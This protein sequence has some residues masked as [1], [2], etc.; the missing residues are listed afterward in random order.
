MSTGRRRHRRFDINDKVIGAFTC[1]G[2]KASFELQNISES[3]V[4]VIT[5]KRL[6]DFEGVI[7]FPFRG[8]I[9]KLRSVWKKPVSHDPV[10]Y[11]YGLTRIDETSDVID[12][13]L[14]AG[15]VDED[16]ID[17]YDDQPYVD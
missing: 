11:K 9:L 7:E 1:D 16:L 6:P 17:G 8:Q 5:Q 2:D 4:C 13:F 3:G 10:V 12:F 14:V 15:K